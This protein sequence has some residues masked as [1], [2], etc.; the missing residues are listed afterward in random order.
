MKSKKREAD[1][2]ATRQARAE[3]ELWG[4][5]ILA[6]GSW[7]PERFRLELLEERWRFHR[8]LGRE[9]YQARFRAW[10]SL[11]WARVEVDRE[12]RAQRVVFPDADPPDAE[13]IPAGAEELRRWGQAALEVAG[14]VA[15]GRPF[16][17]RSVQAYPATRGGLEVRALVEHH[18][19][20]GQLVVDI[21]PRGPGRVGFLCAPL[22]RSS[23]RSQAL[24]RA[25]AVARARRQLALP[26]GARLTSARLVKGG[27]GRV[28]RLRWE[29]ET[30]EQ[31]GALVASLN[32]RTGRPCVF[33]STVAPRV[34]PLPATLEREAAE[35]QMR[36]AVE[37]RLG[38]GARVG[39][40]VPGAVGEGDEL[41]TA[42]LAAVCAPD[43]GVFRAVLDAGRV[44]L[45]RSG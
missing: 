26:D 27:L 20:D 3:A 36:Q 28:W 41:R 44:S 34:R 32:G 14:S 15:P 30:D 16:D 17:L 31:V 6:A 7:G 4:E 24:S 5:E 9:R 22:F 37:R 43:G 35:S 40:L 23:R 11:G 39:S 13:G 12:G 2:E 45:R 33:L 38:P 1:D 18:P 10:E 25:S 21:D 19:L 29:V 42:W 8:A